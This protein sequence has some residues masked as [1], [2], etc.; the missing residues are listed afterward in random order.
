MREVI[1]MQ[2]QSTGSEKNISP[3]DQGLGREA[4]FYQ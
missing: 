2:S 4:S 1:R 3:A